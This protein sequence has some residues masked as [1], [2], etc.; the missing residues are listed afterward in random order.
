M[1]ITEDGA[2]ALIEGT[3]RQAVQDIQSRWTRPQ[4]KHS[5]WEFLRYV[6][7]DRTQLHR[8]LEEAQHGRTVGTA[9]DS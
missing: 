9:I 6:V 4:D 1:T 8:L 2:Q 3:A 5:A 7:Q